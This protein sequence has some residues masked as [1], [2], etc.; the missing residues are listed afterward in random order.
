M[1]LSI[2]LAPEDN[3]VVARI[4]ILSGTEIPGEGVTAL[5]VVPAGHKIATRPIAAGEPVRKYDQIIGFASE[6]VEAGAHVHVH[7]CA[8][9]DFRARLR[10]RAGDEARRFRAGRRAVRA[11]RAICAPTA[12]SA[13]ATISA[14][15]PA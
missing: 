15:S 5:D 1:T 7:N 4:D 14:C 13:P 8:M 9:G 11:S 3:V 6:P 2:R 10:H 12:A